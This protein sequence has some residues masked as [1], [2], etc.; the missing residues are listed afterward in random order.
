MV[1]N[2]VTQPELDWAGVEAPQQA[3]LG[4]GIHLY[5]HEP[6]RDQDVPSMTQARN[7]VR[8]I[9][10]ALRSGQN[11][12]VHCMGGLGRSGTIV[13]CALAEGGLSA[14]EAIAAVR[15]A[16]GPRAVENRRQEDFVQSFIDSLSS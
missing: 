13:A 15:V 12:M 10:G 7:L 3:M 14:Q 1:V 6:I 16:R 11:V 4:G 9:R 2:L 5:I 8:Q